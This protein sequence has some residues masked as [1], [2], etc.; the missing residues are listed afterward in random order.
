MPML[1][2]WLL[3]STAALVMPHA[4]IE[5]TGRS[6]SAP[7]MKQQHL[8]TITTKPW[9]NSPASKHGLRSMYVQAHV[10][11]EQYGGML[12]EVGEVGIEV[13]PVDSYG[14]HGEGPGVK[15][16]PL[17]SGTLFVSP[18]WRRKGIA[19]RLLREAETHARLW[20]FHELLLPVEHKNSGAISLYEKC[21]A[22]LSGHR[23][24][25]AT[26]VRVLPIG[27]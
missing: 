18:G 22:Q 6:G 15:P 11:Q 14:L 3:P 23:T 26:L 5:L 8:V 21:G 24:R 12:K 4:R 7:T 13:L 16:R 20:G 25:P 9:E 27:R 1:L 2:S 10:P 19:Q 17:V